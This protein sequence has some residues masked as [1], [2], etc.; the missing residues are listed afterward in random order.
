VA[1]LADTAVAQ[2]Q[3]SPDLPWFQF[4]KGLAEYRQARFASAADWMGTVLS[5]G[6]SV[7]ERDTGAYMVLA[8]AQ[9]Q[10]QQVEPARASLAKGAEI[11]KELPKLGSGDIGEVWVDWIIAHALMSEAK[12]LIGGQP[13]TAEQNSPARRK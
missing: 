9:C 12:A 1:A 7:L 2:G 10:L 8:M 4:C 11:E 13:A 3:R 6:G 5:N